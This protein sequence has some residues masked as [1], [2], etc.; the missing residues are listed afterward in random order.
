MYSKIT[1]QL[2]GKYITETA[3]DYTSRF[4]LINGKKFDN[5]SKE[6]QAAILKAAAE[7]VKAERDALHKQEE[8]YKQKALDDGAVINEIDKEPFIEIAKPIQDEAAKDMG[9]E[10]LL[11]KIREVE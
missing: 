1:I 6:H 11:Q 8:E 10:G 4:L 5:Y 9:V 2:N 7:S 3:H